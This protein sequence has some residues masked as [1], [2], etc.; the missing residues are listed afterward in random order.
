MTKHALLAASS[1][2][3]WMNCPPSAKAENAVPEQQSLFATEGSFAHD[4]AHML[5]VEY[6][7]RADHIG[8]AEWQHQLTASDLYTQDL[9]DY[10]HIYVDLVIEKINAA[11]AMS[12]DAVILLE[13]KL[14]YS[15]WAPGGFGTGDAVLYA[16]GYLEV[17]DL[18]FGRGVPVSAEDN[19]QL[20]L[21]ALGALNRED[22]FLY[23]IQKVIM[24]IAQPRLD[25]ITSETMSVA[26]LLAWA[27]SEVKPK[28][29]LAYEGKGDFS[30]GDW[31][32]FCKIK[33]TCRKRAEGSLALQTYGRKEP[34]LL[35]I[36]EIADILG[37]ADQLVAWATD[38]KTWALEQAEKHNVSYPG[39]KLVEGRSNRAYIDE[40][41]VANTLLDAGYTPDIIRKPDELLGVTAMEK[42]LGKKRFAEMLEGLVIKPPGKPALVPIGD[43]RPAIN[44]LEAARADFA[45]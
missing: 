28:A 14:D 41:T 19:P 43:K 18:K 24:T 9:L 5:L 16:D 27:E 37:K 36:P 35:T 13:Q 25:S 30:D 4:V 17:I 11:R 38:V 10:V 12:R 45:D 32:R 7:G 20:R 42:L 1:A 6:L 44:S 23:S 15:P 34:H 40:K 33:H 8:L 3:R 2:K 22:A 21:Y 29:Q 31:C 26:E 39:W